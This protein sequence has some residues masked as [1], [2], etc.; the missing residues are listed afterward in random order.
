MHSGH[1]VASV[2]S[3]VSPALPRLKPGQAR[4]LLLRSSLQPAPYTVHYAGHHTSHNT[5]VDIELTQ[6]PTLVSPLQCNFRKIYTQTKGF[7]RPLGFFRTKIT[8]EGSIIPPVKLIYH[9]Q[10][11]VKPFQCRNHEKYSWNHCQ[12]NINDTANSLLWMVPSSVTG[13]MWNKCHLP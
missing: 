1:S 4:S 3:R 12:S 6:T 13:F 10:I 7:L 2:S 11:P 5:I 8:T 9:P